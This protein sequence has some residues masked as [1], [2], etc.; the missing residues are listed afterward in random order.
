MNGRIAIFCNGMVPH[1][2][3]PSGA[4][5]LRA[6]GLRLGF[7]AMGI[8]ADVVCTGAT[9]HSQMHR[10]GLER[11]RVPRWLR[12]LRND[13]CLER[14]S[15]D[16]DTVVLLNWAGL[17]DFRKGKKQKLVYDFFSP[18]MVE[19]AFIAEADELARRRASKNEILRQADVFIANGIGRA[20]YGADYLKEHGIANAPQV[21]SVRLSMPWSGVDRDIQAPI[22]VFFGGFDQAWTRGLSTLDLKRLAE[23]GNIEVHAIG[24]GEH[25]HTASAEAMRPRAKPAR[26]SHIVP[27][28]VSP[29]EDFASINSS[30]DVALDVFE[31]NKERRLSYS[32]R[33]ISSLASGC[34]VLTMGFTEIGK[35]IEKT[36]AGWTLDT[37]DVQAISKLLDEI[38]SDQDGLRERQKATRSFWESYINP[39]T[40][41]RNLVEALS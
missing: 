8:E 27:H 30:C 38:V 29:F 35:L 4:Q 9:V 12:I 23:S 6:N 18:T 1:T 13:I 39:E 36:G 11:M 22:R 33:A 10:W 17:S 15:S 26:D 2:G 3:V 31:T 34:P 5:G 20:E 28:P 32:T 24:V 25:L 21:S 14:L 16:Y 19:H 41:I 40:E 37:Y 7:A